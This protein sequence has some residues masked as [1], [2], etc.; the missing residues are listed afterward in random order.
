M[1][2]MIPKI[3]RVLFAVSLLSVAS[4]A[5]AQPALSSL[6][7]TVVGSEW[8]FDV[9]IE[10]ESTGIQTGTYALTVSSQSTLPS[11]STVACFA[12]GSTVAPRALPESSR[13]SLSTPVFVLPSLL[14]R[15]PTCASGAGLLPDEDNALG[16]WRDGASAW[17]WWW[18]PANP[19]PGSTFS[20]PILTGIQSDAFINGEVRTINGSV[21]TSAGTFTDAV[22][23][24]YLLELGET[25]VIDGGGGLLGTVSEETVG[26]IAFVPGVGPV[27]SEETTTI[28]EIDCP[29]C[30]ASIFDPFT[31]SLDL[32]RAP[33]VPVD[34]GSFGGLKAR[35]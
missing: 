10:G 11:G 2:A 4:T 18:V 24:D 31:K 9:R 22:I 30:P 16:A 35:Y 12:Y 33:V 23:V 14:L 19:A 15:P 34:A 8:E 3:L 32:R 21:A 26:W 13:I 29:T 7:P 25:Q 1:I 20:L 28:T 17:D 27:A 5:T 6:W